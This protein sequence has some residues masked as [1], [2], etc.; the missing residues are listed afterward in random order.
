MTPSLGTLTFEV[1]SGAHAGTYGGELSDDSACSVRTIGEQ[2]MLTLRIIHQREDG[3]TDVFNGN[4]T[5]DGDVAPGDIDL[6]GQLTTTGYLPDGTSHD[7][8]FFSYSTALGTGTL[9]IEQI[10]PEGCA[11]QARFL[12]SQDGVETAGSFELKP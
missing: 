5:V 7:E 3:T 6:T 9:T 10:D 12:V 8:K 4:L 2:T 1:K 11:M